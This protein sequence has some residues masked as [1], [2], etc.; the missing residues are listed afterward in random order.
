MI[1]GFFFWPFS[2]FEGGGEIFGVEYPSVVLITVLETG[3]KINGRVIDY[4]ES[5]SNL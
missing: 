1:G 5:K 3:L 4:I 2:V